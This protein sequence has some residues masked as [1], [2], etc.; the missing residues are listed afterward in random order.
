MNQ[1]NTYI[2]WLNTLSHLQIL[3]A[4]LCPQIN[5]LLTS[6]PAPSTILTVI[7]GAELNWDGTC[8]VYDGGIFVLIKAVKTQLLPKKS[9]I[10]TV[11]GGMSVGTEYNSNVFITYYNVDWQS[12]HA[13]GPIK[14]G[15]LTFVVA[16]SIG[17]SVFNL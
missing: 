10:Y 11:Y 7:T 13:F 12:E 1:W 14:S 6:H 8:N 9:Q 5:C 17:W 4:E 3:S 15:I 2:F 16:K